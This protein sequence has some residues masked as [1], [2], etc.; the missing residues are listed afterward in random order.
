MVEE[1]PTRQIQVTLHGVGKPEAIKSFWF[2]D[3]FTNMNTIVFLNKLD[4][5]MGHI[6]C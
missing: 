4:F 3:A 5:L 1:T 2:E 6:D